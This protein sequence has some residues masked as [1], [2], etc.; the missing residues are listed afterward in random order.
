LALVALVL[1]RRMETMA[2]ILFLELLLPLAVVMA[3]WAVAVAMETLADQA[4]VVALQV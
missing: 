1:V 3:E 4:V 2:L